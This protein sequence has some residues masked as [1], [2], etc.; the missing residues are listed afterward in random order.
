M[1]PL[2]YVKISD[3]ADAMSPVP[4]FFY[5]CGKDGIDVANGAE[6]AWSQIAVP[7]RED[8]DIPGALI[9]KRISTQIIC[10]S[11]RFERLANAY[12]M[13]LEHTTAEA[14]VEG[15]QLISDRFAGHIGIEL[16]GLLDELYALR[17]AV[18]F[19]YWRF[20]AKQQGSFSVKNVRQHTLGVDAG[21][22]GKRLNDLMSLDG[23]LGLLKQMSLHRNVAKHALGQCNPLIGDSYMIQDIDTVFGKARTCLY[24]LYDDLE[25]LSQIEQQSSVGILFDRN[26]D[27]MIRFGNATPHQDGMTF[28]W[29]CFNQLLQIA[30]ACATDSGLERRHVTLSAKD[31]I[32]G[33]FT[34]E[35][36][37]RAF[38]K[39]NT[40]T[41]ELDEID[42]ATF[43]LAE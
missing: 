18:L 1:T 33:E 17:D 7:L 2:G 29:E 13:V 32:K 5:I 12:R 19:S 10:A 23:G 20:I 6:Q 4:L 14:P 42:E 21:D 30:S 3:N 11:R 15:V 34:D 43:R 41:G 28:A 16:I 40:E 39:K 37:T 35:D 38:F 9:A 25:A 27:E 8:G 24:P 36:G 31:I 26:K 22:I